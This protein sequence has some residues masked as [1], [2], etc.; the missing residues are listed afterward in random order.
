MESNQRFQLRSPEEVIFHE[1]F[2]LTDNEDEGLWM[3]AT[4]ILLHVKQYA[5]STIRNVNVRNFGRFLANL[6][7]I[8]SRHSRTGTEYLVVKC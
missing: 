7:D 3:T 1:C 8:V 2:R 6:P 5:G 4:A